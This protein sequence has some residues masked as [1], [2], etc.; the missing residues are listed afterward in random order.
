MSFED[1]IFDKN[2][3]DFY[4]RE[5]AREFRKLNGKTMRAEMILIGGASVLLNYGFRDMTYDIDAIII[6]SSAMKQAVNNV[7]DRLDLPNGWLNTDFMKTK[8]YSSKLREH[9]VYY[10]TFSNIL[11]VRTV[12][13]EFL[14]AMKLMAGRPYKN[15]LSDILGIL[16][17]HK[18]NDVPVTYERI[19]S[20]VKE[21]YGE[22]AVLPEA[23]RKFIEKALKED[24]Y[25]Q[26]FDEIRNSEKKNKAVLINFEE[27]YPGVLSEDN[28]A[29]ILH[30]A[31]EK[32]EDHHDE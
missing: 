23:S 6:S 22:W 3:L 11:T 18:E 28:L 4:L 8:S 20:A 5:L 29:D 31:N 13:A 15:D 26:V 25:V 24:N 10:K 12:T 14:I 21:L 1:K 7:G 32:L 30:K 9:S 17:W 2:N 16:N 27:T 19:Q